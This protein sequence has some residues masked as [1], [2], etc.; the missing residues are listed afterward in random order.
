[1]KSTPDFLALD[2]ARSLLA[3]LR[4]GAAFRGYLQRRAR[5]VLPAIG[6]FVLIAAACAAGVAVFF[7]ELSNWLAL[8]GFLLAPAVL[9][10]SFYVQG[11]AFL[12]WLERRALALALGHR[13]RGLGELPRPP[14]ALAGV[15]LFFP[16]SLLLSVAPVTALVLAALAAG[17][18]FAYAKLD[19]PQ[20]RSRLT[21]SR[22]A[23]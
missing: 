20:G 22:A 12:A 15:A 3:G 13:P 7:A 4:E 19:R 5:L 8:P 21:R 18:P 6:L 11:L 10:A 9:V 23:V 14:W 1:M 2:D 17:L 16:F